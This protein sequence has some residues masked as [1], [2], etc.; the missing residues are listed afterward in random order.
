[1]TNAAE[2]DGWTAGTWTIDP[3]HSE[4]G[5]QARHLGISKVKGT[6]DRFSG[7]I[8]TGES[9]EDSRVEAT[10]EVAS[11]NTNQEQRDQ[12]LRASDFFLADEH[13]TFTFTSTGVTVNG[14]D[15]TVV[16]DLT[17]RGVTKP[18]D[19]AV[20]FGGITVDGYGTKKLGLEAETTINR[21]DFGVSWN[22]PTE[23]GGLTLG[24]NVKITL[25]LQANLDA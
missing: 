25:D 24:D 21:H 8:T 10:V 1:M 2:I 13:P 15:I 19:F 22:A 6:F 16:G 17:L 3:T 5:F 4:V 7:T 18:I 12:H 14:D 9:L 23:A 20:D 11:V